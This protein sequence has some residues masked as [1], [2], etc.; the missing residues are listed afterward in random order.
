MASA[1][2]APL[3]F[4]PWACRMCSEKCCS[5][6]SRCLRATRGKMR[7]KTE[8]DRS[9]TET[10][11]GSGPGMGELSGSEKIHGFISRGRCWMDHLS[12][13]QLTF[14]Q[15]PEEATGIVLQRSRAGRTVG[16]EL[17]L[18]SRLFGVLKYVRTRK[19]TEGDLL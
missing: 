12:I 7:P 3:A 17:I 16:Q 14:L 15:L 8:M 11:R 5:I 18:D 1:V 2:D 6:C 4:A 19:F 10:P 13:A 9:T